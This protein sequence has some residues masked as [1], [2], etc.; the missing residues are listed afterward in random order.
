MVRTV[1]TAAWLAATMLT[2][3]AVHA[4]GDAARGA[5]IYQSCEDC[6]SLDKNEVG[7]KH[8]GVVGRKAGTVAGYAYSPA[9]RNS[10]ITWTEHELDLWLTNPQKLVPGTRMGFRLNNPQ[11]RADVIAFLKK[12]GT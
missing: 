5:M 4:E 3:G 7:P 9:L 10:N 2:C 11:D 8:R 12:N 6:H 1:G